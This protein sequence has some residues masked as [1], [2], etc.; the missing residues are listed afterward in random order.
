MVTG[1]STQFLD[2]VNDILNI[3]KYSSYSRWIINTYVDILQNKFKR[4]N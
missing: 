1:F 4:S 3:I 2:T